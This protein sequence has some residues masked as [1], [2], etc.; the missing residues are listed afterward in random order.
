MGLCTDV[1]TP[2]PNWLEIGP[3]PSSPGSNSKTSLIS[4]SLIRSIDRVFTP[5]RVLA[6]SHQ[7]K[8]IFRKT[9]PPQ[10]VLAVI[11]IT[12]VGPTLENKIPVL[13]C[14][15]VA[16]RAILDKLYIYS[17]RSLQ[18]KYSVTPPK[19]SE[20]EDSRKS[21]RKKIQENISFS[22]INKSD[23]NEVQTFH[24]V[25]YRFQK[26]HNRYELP[27]SLVSVR[28]HLSFLTGQLYIWFLLET[29]YTF[30]HPFSKSANLQILN[31][32]MTTGSSLTKSGP[33]KATKILSNDLMAGF[34]LSIT[35]YKGA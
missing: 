14:S 3:V 16:A 22:L 27:P 11:H 29:Q 23:L 28:S 31:W 33:L 24:T 10:V 7:R 17:L 12:S 20:K 8:T 15:G 2:K 9:A 30:I 19:P 34:S 18:F 5:Y 13:V 26:Y 35:R 1:A 21:S 32:D 25:L 6:G 4:R